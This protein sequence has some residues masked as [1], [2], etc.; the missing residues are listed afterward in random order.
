[1]GFELTAL[2]LYIM[3]LITHRNGA[4]FVHAGCCSSKVELKEIQTQWVV[5]I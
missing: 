1:M 4:T 2:V 3:Q 5:L